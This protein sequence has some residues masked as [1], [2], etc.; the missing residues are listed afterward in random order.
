MPR[1][2]NLPDSASVAIPDKDGRLFAPS[3]A[4]NTSAITTQV[5]K[6]APHTGT[7]LELASGTGQHVVELA[8][9]IPH[10]HWQPTEIDAARRQ[11]INAYV[12]AAN[13]ANMAPAAD[14]DA[15]APG[16]A[17][18]HCEQSLILLSNL[19]HLVSA[20]EAQTLI[21]E[22]AQALRPGGI[23]MIY[24]PFKRANNLTSPGDVEFHSSLQAQ[25]PEIGYKNDSDVL[26][27]GTAAGLSHI[28]T[29]T[30]PANNLALLW[31]RPA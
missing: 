29:G 28:D 11:S 12:A 2:L 19:L 24:G 27:W 9:A 20:P 15:T 16:W 23:L 6:H 1:R 10:L 3:A 13:L 21:S 8:R 17:A 22:A 7:A 4:R 14:L 26:G 5:A 25:D 31:Q 18:K 30:M